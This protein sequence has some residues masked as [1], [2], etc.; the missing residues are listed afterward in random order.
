[1][2]TV[3]TNAR[4][5]LYEHECWTACGQ[6]CHTSEAIQQCEQEANEW[7]AAYYY[8]LTY[9]LTPSTNCVP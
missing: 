4:N 5:A 1:M 7:E 8:H 6:E 2:A 3:N 9:S